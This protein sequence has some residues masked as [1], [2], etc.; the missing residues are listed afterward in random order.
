MTLPPINPADLIPDSFKRQIADGLLD[1]LQKLAEKM[2][3]KVF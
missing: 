2:P 3:K 1:F